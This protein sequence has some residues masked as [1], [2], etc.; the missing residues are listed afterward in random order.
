MFDV[1]NVV[2]VAVIGFFFGV[3]W[4]RLRSPPK[5]S[6]RNKC[7]QSYKNIAYTQRWRRRQ[8]GCQS[9]E[10][11]EQFKGVGFWCLLLLFWLLLLLATHNGKWIKATFKWA[12]RNRNEAKSH[13]KWRQQTRQRLRPNVVELGI[14]SSH[15]ITQMGIWVLILF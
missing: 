11:N 8:C 3:C 2:V 7:G 15:K 14:P 12:L 6:A 9:N 4:L 1:L 5:C 13:Q 10:T